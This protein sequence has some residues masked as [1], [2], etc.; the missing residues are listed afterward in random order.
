MRGRV[1]SVAD[2]MNAASVAIVNE[3]FVSKYMLGM[4][5]IGARIRGAGWN[6]TRWARWAQ[7]VGVVGDE[8][9][10]LAAPPYPEYYIPMAQAPS[11]YT[12]AIVYA[13]NVDSSVISREMKGAFAATLPTVQPPNTFTVAQLVADGT[14]QT[15]F[16]ALLLLVL[17][18]VALALA[19]SG[20]FGVVSFS[21][22]QR[23][24]E[25]GVR[26]ALG[27]STR[28][29]L[30]DVFRRTFATTAIGAAIGLAIAALAAHAIASELGAVSPF[31]PVTFASVVALIFLSAALASLQPAL[32]A[33]RV[34]P[35]EALRY[36]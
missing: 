29:I 36:E 27:A 1:F 14:A 7:I 15:R 18:L 13:P 3:A 8:R 20:V 25:F 22:T 12:S 4:R 30:G 35:V 31:D 16:A 5:P 28:Q 17:A 6:G 19:L 11:A 32:R 2:T 10:N 23:S 33:T 26:I 21:V 24:R 34:Q 9:D